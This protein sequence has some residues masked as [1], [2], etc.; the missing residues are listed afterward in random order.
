MARLI[1]VTRKI[2]EI[3]LTMLAEK[4]Y[5][6]EV[7]PKDRPLAK[8]ELVRALGRKPYD[9]V[10]C[11]LT[12]AIDGEVFDAAP[13]AKIFA[14]YAV[15]FNNVNLDDAKKRGVTVTNTPGGL[16]ESV[17]EHAMALILALTCRIV[18]GDSFVRRGKYK[19]W[20]PLLLLGTDIKGKTLGILGTGRIGGDVAKK[21]LR[22]FEMKVAYYDVVRNGALER[23]YGAVFLPT[24]EEVMRAADVV[25][26]HVPLLPTTHH[27]INRERLALMKKTAYLVNTSRG[28]VVDEAALVDALRRGAIRG[29]GLDVF[30]YEPKLAKGLA[31][32]PN[33]VLTPHI[34]SATESARAEMATLA[35]GNIIAFF[36]GRTPPNVVQ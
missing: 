36:E 27:F 30:E 34:A 11:L 23:D 10:L 35:A 19:G 25:S 6:V 8:R 22:G 17:A 13:S 20:D 9:A 2:P 28:P 4:G 5:T 12:D 18:E 33:V 1:Y 15:G 7:S 24:P 32:L 3:G 14:N 26:V 16:T 29:A 21:A 31:K